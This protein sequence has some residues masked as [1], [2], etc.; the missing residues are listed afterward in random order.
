MRSVSSQT[1][2]TVT[3][4]TVGNPA[5]PSNVVGVRQQSNSTRSS[6]QSLT[7]SS[8]FVIEIKHGFSCINIRQ[9]PRVLKT[10]AYG[11]SFQHLL[12]DLVNVNALKNHVRSLLLHK[13]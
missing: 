6:Q 12:W 11:L 10:E 1:E 5:Y 13:S 2:G 8:R 9:V 3:I 4:I 7:R